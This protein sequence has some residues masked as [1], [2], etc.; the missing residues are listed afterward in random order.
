MSSGVL[1]LI[2][3]LV[4]LI[5]KTLPKAYMTDICRAVIVATSTTAVLVVLVVFSVTNRLFV[6]LEAVPS[7][8]NALRNAVVVISIIGV[9]TSIFFLVS[10]VLFRRDH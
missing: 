7:G 5:I 4:G 10:G 1:M 2:S 6:S 8:W 9:S 3:L